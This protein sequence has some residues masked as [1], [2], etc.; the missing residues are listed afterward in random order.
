ME[1]VNIS[2]KLNQF[3]D[4]WN[5]RILGELNTGNIESERTRKALEKI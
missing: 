1:K 5:P 3:S 4:H 2:E